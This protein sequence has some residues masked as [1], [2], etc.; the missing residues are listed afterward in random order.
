ML[1]SLFAVN[2]QN[3]KIVKWI[4]ENAIEIEFI[5]NNA[6]ENGGGV[7]LLDSEIN[8]SGTYVTNIIQN[9]MKLQMMS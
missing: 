3:N 2:G 8:F 1:F 4:N 5:S 6:N 9:A 7:Y